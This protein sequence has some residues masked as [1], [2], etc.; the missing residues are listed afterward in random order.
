MNTQRNTPDHSAT[1]DECKANFIVIETPSRGNLQA[2]PRSAVY[3]ETGG[4]HRLVPPSTQHALVLAADEKSQI[5]ALQR[6]QPSLP[7]KSGRGQ[8]MTHDYKRHGTATLFAALNTLDGT[9]MSQCRSRYTHKDWIA[10][11]RQIH[12]ETLQ[13]KQIHILRNSD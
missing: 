4:H 5:Q 7:L 12:R 13:D 2:Q 8:S 9:V 6:T 3:R 11:L 1:E 10:F